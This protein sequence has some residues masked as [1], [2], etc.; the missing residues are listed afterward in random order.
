M[1]AM[2]LPQTVPFITP[3]EYLRLERAA[4]YKSEY[5]AGEIFAMAGGTTPHSWIATN[6]AGELRE[7]LKGNKC[8][9]FNS[10]LRVLSPA[11]GLYTYPDVSVF[12]MPLEYAIADDKQE[13]VTN[14]T[15]LVEVL[16]DS[17]EAYDR[18]TKFAHYRSIPSFAEYVLVSQKEPI[19]EVFFKTPEGRW[20]LTPVAGLDGSVPL[21]SLGI[22]LPLAEVYR[23]VTFPA[24]GPL[25][26]TSGRP[27]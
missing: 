12:C 7:R 6:V 3:E 27:A 26:E 17:T 10:D 23:G 1:S 4:E 11:T 9:P 14:P 2:G 20:E 5:F 13:T 15:L 19:V 24:A 18:G 16:S 25:K 21:R 8:T 22:E